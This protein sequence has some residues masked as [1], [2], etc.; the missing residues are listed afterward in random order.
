MGVPTEMNED[1]EV[2]PLIKY[3]GT[4]RHDDQTKSQYYVGIVLRENGRVEVY[5]DFTLVHSF[6]QHNLQVVD[7]ESGGRKFYFKMVKNS[8]TVTARTPYDQL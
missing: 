5:F 7:I 1:E 3:R 2:S 6:Y 4:V 8:D